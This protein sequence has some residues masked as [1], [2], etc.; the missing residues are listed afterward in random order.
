MSTKVKAV[1]AAGLA[2]LAVTCEKVPLTAPAGTS[3]FL[4]CNPCFV[5]ANGGTSLVTAVLTEPAG[6]LVPDGTAV[7]F[8]TTLGRIDEQGLTRD[9]VARVNFVADARSGTARVTAVSGGPAAPAPSTSPSPA[10]GG[11]VTASAHVAGSGAGDIAKDEVGN[12]TGSASITIDIGSKLPATVLVV[13]SPPSITSP[14]QSSIVATVYDPVGNPVQNVPVIFSVTSATGVTL[15]SGGSP[16][17][18]DSNGQAFDTLRTR[19]TTTAA[20]VQVTAT[21]PVGAGANV[22]VSLASIS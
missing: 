4:Q 8:F 5:V 12:G 14:G 15:D 18:T 2:L 19:G 20:S 1:A 13:A 22:T 16:R 6:T 3:M 11:S 7:L 17:F 10:S 21:P 9:G